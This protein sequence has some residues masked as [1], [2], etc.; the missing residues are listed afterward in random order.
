MFKSSRNSLTGLDITLT[1]INNRD[2]AQA[3]R[4]YATGKD[5][6]DISPLVP[7]KI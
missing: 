6:D 7:D 2:V 5:I 4:D 3:E 1:A